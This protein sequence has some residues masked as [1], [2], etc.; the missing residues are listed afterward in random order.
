[1][2]NSEV[3]HSTQQGIDMDNGS[4]GFLTDLTFFGG[5]F[6]LLPTGL[7]VLS[8]FTGRDQKNG[9][10]RAGCTTAFSLDGSIAV[11]IRTSG[12]IQVVHREKNENYDFAI[13]DHLSGG[14]HDHVLYF[15]LD[16]NVLGTANTVA[17]VRTAAIYWDFDNANQLLVVNTNAKNKFGENRGYR[18]VPQGAGKLTVRDASDLRNAALWDEHD[19]HVSMQKDGESWASHAHRNQD[20]HNPPVDFSRFSNGEV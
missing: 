3:P 18:I 12:Y 15:K 8:D 14:M 2:Y 16:F 17:L 20:L 4:G 6:G 7:F 5:N 11:D 19:V 9:R 13:H 1:M 10:W